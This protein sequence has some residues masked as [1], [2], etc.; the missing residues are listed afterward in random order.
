MFNSDKLYR[1]FKVSSFVRLSDIEEI[2]SDEKILVQGIS[3]C[4]FEENGEL[5]LVDYKTDRVK[6]EKQ[7]LS[8]YHN[9]IAFYKKGCFKSTS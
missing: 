2:D 4:V 8:M 5:V 9:Q 7:L 6:T 1:E 3:D